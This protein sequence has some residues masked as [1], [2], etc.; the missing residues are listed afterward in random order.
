MTQEYHPLTDLQWQLL[1]PLF[2]KPIKKG[3]GKPHTPWRSVLNSI[4]AVLHTKAKWSALPKTADF[5]SKSAAHRWF[6]IWDKDG[7]LKQ[8]LETLTSFSSLQIEVTLPP[9]RQRMPKG[10]FHPLRAVGDF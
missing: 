5:A 8:I 3:R 7:F 9:R 1:A 6:V 2:S 4:L 10:E